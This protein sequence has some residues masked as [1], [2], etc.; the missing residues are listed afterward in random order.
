M[1]DPSTTQDVVG[2]IFQDFDEASVFEQMVNSSATADCTNF[3]V[4]FGHDRARVARNLELGHFENLYRERD[5]DYPIRW[6]NI[7]DT[8][9]KPEVTNFLGDQY[10]FSQRMIGIM[11]NAKKFSS[12]AAKTESSASSSSRRPHAE[13]AAATPAAASA[14]GGA[15]L[16]DVQ[17]VDLE[18]GTAASN[19]QS[20][21]AASSSSAAATAHA[22]HDQKMPMLDG[23]D[24]R[25]FLLLKNKVNYSSIDQT[26]NALCIG[27]HWLHERTPL[28]GSNARRSDSS[29]PTSLMPPKHWLWLVLGNDNTVLSLHEDP[30]IEKVEGISASSPSSAWAKYQARCLEHIRANTLSVLLQLSVH[31]FERYA[32]KPL[33]QSSVRQAMLVK[34]TRRI[35]K[36]STAMQPQQKLEMLNVEGASNLFYYLFEDYAA[37]ATFQAAEQT[38]RELTPIVLESDTRKMKPHTAGIIPRLHSLGKDLRELKHLFENYKA[39]IHKILQTTTEHVATAQLGR[40][41][42]GL[43]QHDGS[44]AGGGG[45]EGVIVMAKSARERFERLGERLQ[46]LMLNTIQG[47]QDETIAL[48]DTYFNLMQQKDTAATAR[49]NRSATL[50]AKLSVFF[51][52][53]SFVTSYYSI[54][55]EEMYEAW[56]TWDFEKAITITV[57]VS[58][59]ALFFFNKILFVMID[60]L[61]KMATKAETLLNKGFVVTGAKM[62]E[63]TLARRTRRR[64]DGEARAMASRED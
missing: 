2:P 1:A 15:A 41:V 47:Y 57:C 58:F 52:P 5:P 56:V 3:V 4:E 39:M 23:D 30:V 43:E 21:A 51:L 12:M 42:S 44:D 63:S 14:R 49:L 7:W 25:L 28:P 62:R 10:E 27:A 48:S 40:S 35:G 16:E 22:A 34:H 54:Q 11:Q 29:K 37:A 9:K 19:T 64:K 45:E 46:W 18:K 8:S 20:S 53:L 59:V 26:P 13:T 38:L 61:D 55:I 17:L 32:H 31:G 50:L 24:V 6:I 36:S 60:A 33:S